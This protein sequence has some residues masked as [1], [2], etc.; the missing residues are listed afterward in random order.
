MENSAQPSRPSLDQVM[1]T[2][3][4]VQGWMTPGQASTLYDSA[5]NCPNGSQIVEIGS[6]QG[7]STIVLASAADPSITVIAIDPHA[8]NDRGPQEID[9]FAAEADDDHAIFKKNLA[10]AGVT[11]RVQ[12]LRM[13]SDDAHGEVTG[14]IGVLYVDGA[15]RYGPARADIASWG[16]RVADGGT[17]LIHDSFSSIGVTLAIIRELAVGSKFRYVGRS[18]SMTIYRADL[19]GGP[20]GRSKNAARQ[21]A[22]LPWFV[23]NVGQKVLLTV[24]LGKV[25]TKLG[26]TAPEWPY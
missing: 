17:L 16:A 11:D 18:R 2:V 20:V 9:G 7:R 23:K 14:D 6:F 25:M 19:N 10:E 21:L 12:H 24:G 1:T 4:D 22:Q 26:R 8:G 3:A 13:F 15:H 5:V